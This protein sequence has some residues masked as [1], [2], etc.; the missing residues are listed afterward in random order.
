MQ[1]GCYTAGVNET[2][3]Q[4]AASSFQSITGVCLAA[5]YLKG[6]K[7]CL[8]QSMNTMTIT[9]CGAMDMLYRA[10]CRCSICVG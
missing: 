3:A 10:A 7:L 9:A 8:I 6:T 4:A 1:I 2:L 5:R